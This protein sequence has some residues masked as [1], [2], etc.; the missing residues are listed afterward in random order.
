MRIVPTHVLGG[1]V[2]TPAAVNEHCFLQGH[3]APVFTVALR[4]VLPNPEDVPESESGFFQ[5]AGQA[6]RP[7][8][9]HP[10]DADNPAP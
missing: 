2:P 10:E 6:T 7:A 8:A 9:V 1:P 3:Y 4:V 5:A